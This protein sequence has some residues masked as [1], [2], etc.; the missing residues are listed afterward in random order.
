MFVEQTRANCIVQFHPFPKHLMNKLD[1]NHT[2]SFNSTEKKEYSCGGKRFNGSE[3]IEKTISSPTKCN[4]TSCWAFSINCFFIVCSAYSKPVHST[5]SSKESIR[6]SFTGG[7]KE[8]KSK[9][10]H[11]VPF[12]I[13]SFEFKSYCSAFGNESL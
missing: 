13:K 3:R 10:A 2:L 9:S 4:S 1:S 7:A 6:N 5:T 12:S 11:T 8:N